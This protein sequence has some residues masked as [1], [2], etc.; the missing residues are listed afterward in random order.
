MPAAAVDRRCRHLLV[1]AVALLLSLVAGRAHAEQRLY[2][3]RVTTV[4][5]DRYETLSSED[6]FTYA[7]LIGAGVYVS[8][9]YERIWSPQAKVAVVAT[10]IEPRV[11]LKK[12]WLAI[13]REQGLL[14][15]A[16]RR[17]LPRRPPLT[18]AEMRVPEAVAPRSGRAP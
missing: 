13:L 1:G 17:L 15:S 12:Y 5:G 3:L 18:A 16:N 2:L 11:P 10:W 4:A 6:P 14:A 8:R 7:S 9:D